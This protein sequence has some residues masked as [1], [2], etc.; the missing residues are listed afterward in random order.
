M[1]KTT[2]FAMLALTLAGCGDVSRMVAQTTGYDEVCVHGVTYIQF[3]S[4]AALAVNPDGTP[5]G[6][7]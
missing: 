4:G 6:C 2:I 1:S 5:R 7:Q 3:V